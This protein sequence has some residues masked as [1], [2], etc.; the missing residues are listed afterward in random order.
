MYLFVVVFVVLV[1][2]LQDG[3]VE[4]Q[5]GETVPVVDEEGNEIGT[6]HSDGRVLDAAGKEIGGLDEEGN[7]VLYD[8]NGEGGEV[9]ACLLLLV[10]R[11]V[12]AAVCLQWHVLG[13][14]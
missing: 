9:P 3:L 5:E 11:V 4:L 1:C 6:L 14:G 13:A 8:V 12:A 2:R 10:H 7:V